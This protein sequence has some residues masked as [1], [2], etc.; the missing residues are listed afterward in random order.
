MLGIIKGVLVAIQ[1]CSCCGE[2]HSEL[3]LSDR[4]FI[5]PACSFKID[6]NLNA[7]RNLEMYPELMAA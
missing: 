1:R 3:K 7:A 6:R 5:C 4:T 2:K